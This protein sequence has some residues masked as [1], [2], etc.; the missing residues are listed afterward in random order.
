MTKE[1]PTRD[2]IFAV[3]REA[4]PSSASK[5][6]LLDAHG[7][8]DTALRVYM[9][10]LAREGVVERTDVGWRLLVDQADDAPDDDTQ[11][12]DHD[13]QAEADDQDPAAAE[14]P[15]DDDEPSAPEEEPAALVPAA[16]RRPVRVRFVSFEVEGD[17]EAGE[18]AG[19]L[20][21]LRAAMQQG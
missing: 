19:F 20:E 13:E 8:T 2:R 5:Q 14:E 10:K 17:L 7:G 11:D 3:L 12:Q 1:T 9:S 6:E 16:E 15:G 4:A 21:Q 18:L